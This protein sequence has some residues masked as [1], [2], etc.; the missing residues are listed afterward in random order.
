MSSSQLEMSLPLRASVGKAWAERRARRLLR[1]GAVVVDVETTDFDGEIV[2][3]AI[4]D[5]ATGATMLDSIVRP[6]GSIAP[7]AGNIHGITD[8]MCADAPTWPTVWP[9][10]RQNLLGRPVVAFNAP[11]DRGRIV[12]DCARH[13]LPVPWLRWTCLMRLDTRARGGWRWRSL[14]GG[15]RAGTDAAAAARLLREIASHPVLGAWG[16][17]SVRERPSP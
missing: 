13:G 4:V 3:V 15:H 17:R 14:Q 5:A 9:A 12:A 10:V 7:D 11:F 6:I 1:T 2:E 16:V 8:Q